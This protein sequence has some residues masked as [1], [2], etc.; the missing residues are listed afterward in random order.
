MR[1]AKKSITTM[2]EPSQQVKF[3]FKI[4]F[5]RVTIGRTGLSL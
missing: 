2:P 4:S 3:E 5:A 1:C